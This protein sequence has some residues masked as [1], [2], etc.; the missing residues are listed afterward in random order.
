MFMKGK[1]KMGANIR[2]WGRSLLA[3]ILACAIISASA[4]A[5]TNSFFLDK[6][7]A[8]LPVDNYLQVTISD[9][10]SSPDAIDVKTSNT[11]NLDPSTWTINFNKNVGSDT[12]WDYAI[13][14]S[15]EGTEFFATHVGDFDANVLGES[16]TKAKFAD[17]TPVPI[18]STVWILGAGLIGLIVIRRKFLSNIS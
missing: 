18:P 5:D 2:T 8:G 13:G 12:P 15:G 1:K 7:N 17:P 3:P 11:R 10:T 4:H 6:N 9:S 14:N 16:V